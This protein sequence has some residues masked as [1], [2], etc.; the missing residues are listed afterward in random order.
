MEVKYTVISSLHN[1]VTVIGVNML[2]KD[3]GEE[4]QNNRNMYIIPLILEG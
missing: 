3:N 2:N 4:L 1:P